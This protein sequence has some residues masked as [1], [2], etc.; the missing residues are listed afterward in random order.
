MRRNHPVTQREVIV[1]SGQQLI[2]T[3]NLKG[4]ITDVNDDF[5]AVSGFSRDELI[6]QAH[7]IIRHPDMPQEAFA[8]LWLCLKMGRSWKGVVKNRCKNGDHYWVDAYVTPIRRHGAI[9]E[10]QSVRVTP[11]REQVRRAE[12]L[13]AVWRQGKLPLALRLPRMG[14][15]RRVCAG[16]LLPAIGF[17]SVGYAIN[18]SA[19]LLVA[20]TY[21]SGLAVLGLAMGPLF[22]LER[23]A[24]GGSAARIMS[25]IYTGRQDEVG[26]V[27]F[28]IERRC[29]ELLAVA[30]RIF[31][32]SGFLRDA[33]ERSQQ[34]TIE[35]AASVEQQ[36]RDVAEICRAAEHL[37]QSVH[38]VATRAAQSSETAGQSVARTEEGQGLVS[39]VSAAVES[40]AQNL[41]G[42]RQ[43]IAQLEA[44]S[45]EIGTVVD[46]IRDVAEQTNLLALNAAIEAAR[47]GEQ[48]RG[49]AVV[50]DEVRALARRT[51]ESTRKIGSIVEGLQADTASAVI[52]IDES[53]IT[54]GETVQLGYG[55]RDSLQETLQDVE[56]IAH[57]MQ[58][59]AAANEEQATL[60]DQMKRQVE[61]LNDLS[62]QSLGCSHAASQEADQLGQRIA[63]IHLL[64]NHFLEELA[65]GAFKQE[66]A[67][68]ITPQ[69]DRRP[70]GEQPLTA[71]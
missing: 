54:V 10:Y 53:V 56:R 59:I 15:W 3:T 42:A 23:E 38:E 55:V 2:T 18:L 47:A 21:V 9:V 37:A 52:A 13:Y 58:D 48:G 45:E 51:H 34:L 67:P 30:A 6:G 29:S 57:Y 50:A 17:A 20:A 26:L 62:E 41:E 1:P 16:G 32:S 69:K 12:S 35:S 65:T 19:A 31:Y 4:V 60:G 46:V 70:M 24:G 64:A 44:R 71:S 33:T 40:L 66:P 61:H 28:A 36:Q 49:F 8:D 25:Y 68:A 43:R 63:D 39:Q 27:R 22:R 11:E 14:L 5:V 7:N